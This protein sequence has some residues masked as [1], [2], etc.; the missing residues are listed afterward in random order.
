MHSADRGSLSSPRLLWP[1]VGVVPSSGCCCVRSTSQCPLSAD[2]LVGDAARHPSLV[3]RSGAG[4][5]PIA[6]QLGGLPRGDPGPAVYGRA[7]SR[8]RHQEVGVVVRGRPDACSAPR[9]VPGLGP[10]S[11]RGALLCRSSGLSPGGLRGAP[12]TFDVSGVF[13]GACCCASSSYQ[14]CCGW[15]PRS[16]TGRPDDR[17]H[18]RLGSR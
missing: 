17:R 2:L 1:A 18:G 14:M 8:R 12:P 15:R 10:R 13:D 16:C 3:H 4:S 9:F 6:Q 7:L 11:S 5:W